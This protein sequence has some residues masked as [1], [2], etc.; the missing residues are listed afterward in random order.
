[1]PDFRNLLYERDKSGDHFYYVDSEDKWETEGTNLRKA[2]NHPILTPA[3]L[4]VSK[5]FSQ[6]EFKVV[7]KKTG[8]VQENHW[9]VNLLNTP[10]GYQTQ[11]DFLETLEF[12]LIAQGYVG[13]YARK[14]PG[15][16]EPDDLLILNKDLIEYP[17]NFNNKTRY[18]KSWGNVKIK[19]DREGDNLDIKMKHII[20]LYDLPN[21][22]QKNKFKSKSRIDGLDQTLKNTKDSLTA[23]NIILK[24]NGK[25]L[26]TG[27]K[28]SFP[29]SKTEKKDAQRL[30]NSKY[31]LGKGR[32]R[33]LITKADISW[34][35]LHIA[36]RDLGLD[37][38]VKVDGNLIYTALHI[39]KDIMSLEAKKT[40]Y[41]NFKES[42]VSY[43]QN[44][45]Q[46]SINALCLSFS[47][48]L[49]D[50]L[51]LVGSYEHLPVM[52]FIRIERFDGIKKQGE[53]LQALLD[54]GVPEELA[55]EMCDFP[56][57][58][59]LKPK[60]KE[61]EGQEAATEDKRKK[62]RRIQG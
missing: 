60:P 46:S 13:I 38:S 35:S 25:E 54:A 1:M 56:A 62:L 17:K 49:E 23:K 16:D 48:L 61:N 11:M 45:M 36:L 14:I 33:G 6:A 12:M 32:S 20:W 29:L 22:M 31:G 42:M 58:T 43:I 34:Q 59:K 50:G 30:F 7:N 15:F 2:Q 57:G 41:N 27:K 55:L 40:T 3:I 53:A 37:E 44:E 47:V 19:Y 5:L 21:L 39:P 10:N 28:G 8:V 9:M 18:D 24:T 4:F 52:Q 51:K 26:I